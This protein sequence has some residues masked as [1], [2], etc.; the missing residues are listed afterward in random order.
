MLPS[1][2]LTSTSPPHDRFL[3]ALI[4]YLFATKTCHQFVNHALFFSCQ[5]EDLSSVCTITQSS[6]IFCSPQPLVLCL[7]T[8]PTFLPL[9]DTWSLSRTCHLPTH[10]MIVFCLH[11]DTSLSVCVTLTLIHPLLISDDYLNWIITFRSQII[12][13]ISPKNTLYWGS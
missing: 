2:D 6:S 7:S 3:S 8:T 9:L 12:T 1:E 4:L 13:I 5:A 11:Q 10:R